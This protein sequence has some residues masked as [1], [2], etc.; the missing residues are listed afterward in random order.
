VNY[1]LQLP[2][3]P[4]INDY[5]GHHCKFDYGHH[6]KFDYATIYVK[7]KG[8]DY[9]TLVKDYV[10]KNNLVLHANVPLSLNIIINPSSNRRWDLDNRLKCVFDALT[11][12]NVWEDD[13][14]IYKMTV[15]KGE[16]IK[17]NGGIMIEIAP[18]KN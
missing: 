14:L 13:S 12:A 4:S 10:I 3:P 7:T 16:V 2:I 11:H 8:K 6:C 9:R 17:D 1:L 18:Y 5:Y 15:E